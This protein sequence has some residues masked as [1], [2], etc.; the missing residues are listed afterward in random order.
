MYGFKK[1]V[2][3]YSYE[4]EKQRK[5]QAVIR[6][7]E[8]SA[9]MGDNSPTDS[10]LDDYIEGLLFAQQSELEEMVDSPEMFGAADDPRETKN[11]SPLS[12]RE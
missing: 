10:D 4:R 8:K 12:N 3:D 5:E 1:Q 2:S 7:K 9:Y 11:S 6:E